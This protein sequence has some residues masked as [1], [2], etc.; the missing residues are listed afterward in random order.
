[1]RRPN[2][3]FLLTIILLASIG[4]IHGQ[5]TDHFDNICAID[6]WIDVQQSEGWNIQT[7]EIHDNSLTHP[8]YFTMMPYTVSWFADWRGPLLYKY[9]QGDFVLTG[10]ITVSNRAGDDIPGSAYSLGGLMVRNPKSFTNGL[11]GWSPGE[12][13]YVFLSIGHGAENHPSCPG[14]PGPHFEVKS[15]INSNSDLNLS[16]VDTNTAD[17]RLIR[18]HPYVLVLYRFPGESWVVHRRYFRNDLQDSVQVGMVTYTDWDKVFTY[19]T[20][21]HNSHVLNEDL[22]PDPS[23]NPWLPFA[24]DI[25]TRYDFL[26]LQSSVMPPQWVGLNLLNT[27]QVS[28]AEILEYFGEELPT[29]EP[30]TEQIWLGRTN[31]H[32]DEP[33]NWLSGALPDVSSIV[34][35]NSCACPEA[36]CVNLDLGTTTIGG[37]NMREGSVMTVP[38]GSTLVV[39]GSVV[40]EGVIVV[41]GTLRVVT[42]G[43]GDVNN[44]G[45]IESRGDGVVEIMD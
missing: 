31:E 33:S 3:N 5:W 27:G 41:Y 42:G 39:N 38:V 40:N 7:L 26:E 30:S 10:N 2:K 18:L 43:V 45:T 15:T 34:R 28:D 8:G 9:A 23:V 17:L 20:A 22:D 35:V 13:D 1:V 37:L 16:S 36:Y 25:I 14:C 4:N 6:Q 32:W 11:P 29:P 44:L 19:T 12:E 21:F 24:P